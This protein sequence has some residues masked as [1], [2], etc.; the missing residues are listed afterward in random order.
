MVLGIAV[1]PRTTGLFVA[2]PF[3]FLVS[4][5]LNTEM[6]WKANIQKFKLRIWRLIWP[7]IAW[8]FIYWI[9]YYALGEVNS[10]KPL[11]WQIFTGHSNQLN[12]TMWFQV[13]LIILTMLFWGIFCYCST[14]MALS[15]VGGLGIIALIIQYSGLNY[16]MFNSLSFELKYPLGRM[17][18]MLPYASLGICLKYF[19]ILDKVKQQKK[20]WLI[21]TIL[22]Y[23]ISRF[24]PSAPGF[25]YSGISLIA[26]ALAIVVVT[27]CSSSSNVP[28]IVSV[29]V[30][31]LSRYTLGI[32]CMHRLIEYLFFKTNILAGAMSKI[33]IEGTFVKCI[34]IYF[35]CYVI[36]AILNQIKC[37]LIKGLVN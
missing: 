3:F 29:I 20:V 11:F 7:Q 6:F 2:V 26:F 21:F 1:L 28:Y 37:K 10:I 16:I 31:R 23:I 14:G 35:L 30:E 27:Y 12:A 18:E 24:L 33:R 5:V 17:V 32:Y 34:I 22:L 19:G 13:V 15:V 4:F 36:S 9:I 8:S 25:G